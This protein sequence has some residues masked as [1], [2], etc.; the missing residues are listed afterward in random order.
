MSNNGWTA[1]IMASWFIICAIYVLYN[2]IQCAKR[3]TLIRELNQ[4]IIDSMRET[5]QSQFDIIKYLKK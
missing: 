2:E 1:I 4:K 3:I 5:I